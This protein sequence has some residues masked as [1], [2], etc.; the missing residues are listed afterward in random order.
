[1]LLQST[2]GST[3]AT[4]CTEHPWEHKGGVTTPQP[5][6]QGTAT[7]PPPSAAQLAQAARQRLMAGGGSSVQ[8]QSLGGP[9]CRWGGLRQAFPS[10]SSS[11]SSCS[12]WKHRVRC[13]LGNSLFSPG[14]RAEVSV[15]K[16][17]TKKPTGSCFLP[18]LPGAALASPC[19]RRLRCQPCRASRPGSNILTSFWCRGRSR[20]QL[21]Q[22]HSSLPC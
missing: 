14:G 4:A 5:L 8:G 16:T 15:L 19:P 21:T 18:A 9:P 3:S 6:S 7:D 10:S 1:M 2:L 17:R 22:I 20:L 11:S 12:A 13:G